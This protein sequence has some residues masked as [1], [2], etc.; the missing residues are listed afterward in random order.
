VV[1]FQGYKFVEKLN[2]IFEDCSKIV[3]L[4]GRREGMTDILFVIFEYK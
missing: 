3:V 2:Y 1:S 4:K